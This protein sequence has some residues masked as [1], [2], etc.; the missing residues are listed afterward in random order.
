MT[1]IQGPGGLACKPTYEEYP[2]A[3][4]A[5]MQLGELFFNFSNMN[6]I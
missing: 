1:L 6:A 2:I 3:E 4:V 5:D